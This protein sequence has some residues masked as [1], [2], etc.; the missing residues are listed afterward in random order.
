MSKRAAAGPL[1]F[2]CGL[3][4]MDVAV[5]KLLAGQTENVALLCFVSLGL[6]TEILKKFLTEFFL[7]NLSIHILCSV[8]CVWL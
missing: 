3:T 6:L 7:W 1:A 5:V 4:R 2:H 8:F